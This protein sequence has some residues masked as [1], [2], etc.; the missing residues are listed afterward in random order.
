MGAAARGS[1]GQAR[2]RARLGG[3]RR[4][5][6]RADHDG[7]SVVAELKDG[8]VT[9]FEVKPEDAGL[10]APARGPQRRRPRAKPAHARPA[11]RRKRADPR[12]R[13]AELRGGLVVA[14]K[15]HDLREGVAS[16]ARRSRRGAGRARRMVAITNEPPPCPCL[17]SDILADLRDQARGIARA[18]AARPR[19]KWNAPPAAPRRPAASAA[20]GAQSPRAATD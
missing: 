2:Q 10:P 7:T 18:K 3:P 6:G 13:A 19:P 5:H 11:R 20:H 9:S 14:G 1:A 16:P 4:G 8:K 17:M 15:A 12:H